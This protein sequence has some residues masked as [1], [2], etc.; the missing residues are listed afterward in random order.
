MLQM[1]NVATNSNRINV[2]REYG[3]SSVALNRK[4]CTARNNYN[5]RNIK[6]KIKTNRK[7]NS[8]NIDSICDISLIKLF[9]LLILG[10]N[11]M[12]RSK[13]VL[14]IVT[15][16]IVFSVSILLS[17]NVNAD[18]NVHYYKYYQTYTVQNGDTLW[19]IAGK[20]AH[21]E[22]KNS[23]IK[24]VAELND[25]SGTYI[26]AG[27]KLVIPYYSTEFNETEAVAFN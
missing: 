21:D 18:N 7:T 9:A 20:F 15:L 12:L 11:K 25:M 22:S 6:K 27:Q 19:K 13:V 14:T 16:V 1:M 8:Y 3:N 17:K 5:N 2:Y 23:Y 26:V 4:R 24:E 10:F